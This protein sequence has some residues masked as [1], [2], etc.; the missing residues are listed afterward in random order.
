MC[1]LL[2]LSNR[3]VVERTLEREAKNVEAKSSETCPEGQ[4]GLKE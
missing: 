2:K 3:R 4:S 1:N